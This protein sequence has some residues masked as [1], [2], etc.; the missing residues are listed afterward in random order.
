MSSSVDPKNFSAIDPKKKNEP[1]D[2]ESLTNEFNKEADNQE[3][4]LI[5]LAKQRGIPLSAEQG[6]YS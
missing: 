6:Q 3:K 4:N 5:A 2:Y 1:L